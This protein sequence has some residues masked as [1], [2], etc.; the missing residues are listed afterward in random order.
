VRD[1][2]ACPYVD[3]G[4][5]IENNSKDRT[6]QAAV[7]AGADEIFTELAPGY[8]ACC[9]RALKEAAQGADVVVLCEIHMASFH[10]NF[11]SLVGEPL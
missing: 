10:P 11:V 3:R 2:K 5:V 4:V 7:E 8:G 9:M 1:F 6:F